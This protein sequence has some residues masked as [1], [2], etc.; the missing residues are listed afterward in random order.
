MLPIAFTP[1]LPLMEP[2]R[3]RKFLASLRAERDHIMS[4]EPDADPQIIWNTLLM[5]ELT[6]LERLHQSLAHGRVFAAEETDS[7]S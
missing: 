4:V 6:P 2:S 3:H 1:E 7:A 5:L